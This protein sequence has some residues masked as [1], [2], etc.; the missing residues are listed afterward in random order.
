MNLRTCSFICIVAI[1]SILIIRMYI[2]IQKNNDFY[3][4]RARIWSSKF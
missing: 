2:S 1:Y 3:V 4:G